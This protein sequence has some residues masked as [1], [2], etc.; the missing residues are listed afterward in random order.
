MPAMLKSSV[1]DFAATR[2]NMVEGQLRPNRVS[3][4]RILAAMG[5]IPRELFVPFTHVG[6][7]YLDEN[8]PLI[9]G[10]SLMQP[11]VLAR[12]LQAAEIAPGDRVLELAPGTG[13][14]T[15]VLAALASSVFSIE[16]DAILYQEVEKNIAAYA[17]GKAKVLAGAPV[18][19]CIA[20][21]PF[22]VIFVNGSVEF[23]PEVLFD[24]L[25]EGGRLV[26]VMHSHGAAR[27]AHTGQARLYR[28][29]K[30]TIAS[31]SLFDAHVPPAPGFDNPR[32][33]A[34]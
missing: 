18:E 15:L 11:M 4:P 16:P 17:A 14:S 22:D 12:L 30:G 21:A 19:G 10:R 25:A 29:T 31:V 9:S 26:A 27:A 8:I 20:H 33:F 5:E 24:Q 28:K 7:A 23:L 34:F 3:D 13:Y 6:V 1:P 2:R 32:G